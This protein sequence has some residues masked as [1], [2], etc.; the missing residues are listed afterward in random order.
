MSVSPTWIATFA[1]SGQAA[2]VSGF[3]GGGDFDRLI[4]RRFYGSTDKAGAQKYGEEQRNRRS[5]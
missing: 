5:H 2:F 3:A 4:L 1:R